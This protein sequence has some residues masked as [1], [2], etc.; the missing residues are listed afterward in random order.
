MRKSFALLIVAVTVAVSIPAFA[1]LQ[2]VQVGGSIRIRGNYWTSEAGPDNPMARNRLIDPVFPFALPIPVPGNVYS[3]WRGT[4]GN[5]AAVPGL[6]LRW[7]GQPGRA[8]VTSPVDWNSGGHGV[9]F[10]EQKT[11]L[12]VK[13]DFTD[14][15]SAFVELD[16][17]DIWGEDFRSN[18]ITGADSRAVTGNPRLPA[19]NDVEVYQSYIEANEMFGYPLRAR[20]G[21]Q[22]LKLGSGWLVGT[23]DAGSFFTG[24]SF[25]GLRLTY[26]TDQFSVDAIAA[27]LVERSPAE[28][29]GDTDMYALYGSYLGIENITLDAYWILVRDA[30]KQVDTNRGWLAEWWQDVLGV[31]DY[32][33]TM[34]HTIGL[35]GAGTFG[36]LDFEGELAYQFGDASAVGATFARQG[37]ISAFGPDDATFGNWGGNAQVGYTFDM[38]YTPRVYAGGAYFGGEDNRDVNFWNWLGAIACPYWHADASVSFNRLFSDW[39]Y[40]NF[41]GAQNQDC[42]NLWVAYGGVS[43]MPVENLKIDLSLAYV[44]SL[45]DFSSPWATFWLFGS[46]LTLFRNWTFLSDKN[47][48]DLCWDLNLKGTYNYSEDLSFE[49]GWSH[50]FV[51]SGAGEGNFNIGNGLAFEGGTSK[52]DAD[53]FYFETKLCF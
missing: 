45:E 21:R 29:D 14:S 4:P 23:N 52:D 10:V 37:L 15:V 33:V 35:R 27:K 50:L 30:L 24:L 53:Y 42:T 6:G 49:A 18:Y 31:D 47:P 11:K 22:E 2:N 46:R 8:R 3:G 48:D 20:I 41:V 28:E 12:N 36:A 51:G 32:D 13:A 19:D 44:Q 25:D 39:Q 1:E 7:P 9:K 38:N 34:L 5:P 16:S 40:G 26:A 43:A 17:Y